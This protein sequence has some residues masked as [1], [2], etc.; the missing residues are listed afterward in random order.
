MKKFIFLSNSTSLFQIKNKTFFSI[1]ITLLLY[2]NSVFSQTPGLIFEPA[3][4]ASGRLILDPNSDG[5][6]SETTNG[7]ITSDR[8]ESEIP[9][10]PLVFPN[11]EPSSDLDGGP[12]CGFTDF[13]ESIDNDPAQN[14]FDADGNWIFRLRMA[15][16]SS[17]AKSYSI[18]I[19]SNGLFGPNDPNYTASNPGFE[20]EIVLATKFGVYVYDHR[21]SNATPCVP[22]I[23]YSGTD[24]YQ[25]AIALSTICSSTN[26]FLDFFVD[27]A[28]IT[29]IFGFDE[30]TAFRSAIISNMAAN[31]S[32]ICNQS[33]SSDMGGV[34][35]DCGSFESCLTTI[36]EN[37]APCPPEEINAGNCLAISAPPVVTGPLNTGAT[38][39]SGT[40]TESDGTVIEIFV[41]GVSVGTT[42]VA[43]GIWS[44]TGLTAL[45]SGDIITAKATAPSK[46]ESNV[47]NSVIVGATCTA[48]VLT[49][50]DC[51]KGI[52]GTSGVVGATIRIYPNNSTTAWTPTAGST[53]DT[54]T[55]TIIVTATG[56]FLWKK[57]S[58][59]GEQTGCTSGG[60]D[61]IVDGSYRITQ[62]SGSQCESKGIWLCVGSGTQT[63]TP[64]ITTSPITT[65]T[66][67]ISGTATIGATVYININSVNV[68]S[69]IADGSG[70]WTATSLSFNGCD[71]VTA[72]ALNST[73]C[74]SAASTSSNVSGS[75]TSA[76]TINGNYCTTTNITTV[77]GTSKEDDGTSIQV[78]NNGV[79][80]GAAV[81]IANGVWT[82]TPVMIPAGNTITAKATATA[83]C[84]TQSLASTG[85]VVSSKNTNIPVITTAVITEGN[86]SISG[87]G[88]N[89]DVISLFI[90]GFPIYTDLAETT[91]ATTTVALS[92]WTINTIYST[93][94]YTGG[95]VTAKATT[96]AGCASNESNIKTVQCLPPATNKT[97]EAVES[98][99][100]QTIEN[101]Q[102]KITNSDSFV[103]YTPVLTDAGNTIFGYSVLGNG[104]DIYLKT[105][106]I[107]AVP[108][109]VTISAMKIGGAVCEGINTITD[110]FNTLYLL[111]ST[112]TVTASKN[113]IC[114]QEA[115]DITIQATEASVR[116]KLLE[117]GTS[118]Y[119]G[120][121]ITGDGTNQDINT[122]AISNEMDIEIIAS[123]YYS[124]P[125]KT[126]ETTFTSKVSITADLACGSILPIE[127]LYFQ[128]E[129][130][131]EEGII[132]NW[133]TSSEKNNDFFTL[134]RSTDGKNWV[135]I[136][137]I[138]GCG[139]SNKLVTYSTTDFEPMTHAPYYKLS[140]T[141]FDGNTKEFDI[142]GIYCKFD[143]KNIQ[144]FPV[145]TDAILNLTFYNEHHTIDLLTVNVFD[146]SGHL[147]KS[148]PF[149]S[150]ADQN[151][152]TLNVSDLKSGSYFIQVMLGADYFYTNPFIISR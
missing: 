69:A 101:G 46:A 79:A 26:Y 92:V 66:T 54:G 43:S 39:V 74:I 127:L 35:S 124:V 56:T 41:D 75:Q 107:D 108:L 151:D 147:I 96:G 145:P 24:N 90:D 87:T 8:S 146:M 112:K 65:S 138:A 7:F 52:S 28:D 110:F 2:T 73:D 72:Q 83:T 99:Y 80:T 64:A 25:K 148:E 125:D 98:D 115:V 21:I 111:P 4:S 132:I 67:S 55:S 3:G 123:I 48:D 51:G 93:A 60:G 103:I 14:Y 95:D 32:T 76:P 53:W 49:A 18:F 70:D 81:T 40:S 89:G 126:C 142:V 129:C 38:V 17:N 45:S 130:G 118:N 128:P 1:I 47:S 137:T 58:Q 121:S 100:C 12:D 10:I 20:M 11:T 106:G 68:T 42:T 77:N 109:E 105:Y 120:S 86:T 149:T 37:Q 82:A 134:L 136:Q 63:A 150:E 135:E 84:K 19:D 143:H 31:K 91:L 57:N 88:T 94:L 122:G 29:T 62:Q 114:D 131:T 133:A 9:F 36:I 116:Y 22:I 119:L 50:I 15:S 33:S 61:L 97:I 144:L 44:K 71:V 141:D 59:T 13:V 102:I 117:S 6:I 78:Y 27:L 23:S 113:A 140:Q 152:F 85:V 34:P 16:T 30:T 104:S 139:N 5:Y